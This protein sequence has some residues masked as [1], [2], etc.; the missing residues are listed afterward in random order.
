MFTTKVSVPFLEHDPELAYR[1]PQSK[2]Q[3]WFDKNG[4]VAGC[5]Y[6]PS[7]AINQLEMW[8]ESTFSPDLI[9]KE[10]AMA[11]DLGFNTIRVFLHQLVWEQDGS[12][13]QSY[14]SVSWQ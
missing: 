3:E 1:W 4:W 14:R 6:I 7:N 11:A 13:P 12:L 5:N 10:L 2:A 8:Q 9:K